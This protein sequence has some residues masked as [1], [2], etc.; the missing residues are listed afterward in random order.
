MAGLCRAMRCA[1]L[2]LTPAD[3]RAG[4]AVLSPPWWLLRVSCTVTTPVP[5]ATAK[6]CIGWFVVGCVVAR[7]VV[8]VAW[9]HLVSLLQPNTPSTPSLVVAAACFMHRDHACAARDCEALH[10]W[11]V[12]GCVVALRVLYVALIVASLL[13]PNTPRA[14]Q[15]MVCGA[16]FMHRDHACAARDCGAL[17]RVVC[18]RLRGMLYVVR[19]AS[20]GC[21]VVAH[22]N[23]QYT[24][25]RTLRSSGCS[26][27]LS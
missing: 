12:V 21:I 10:G 5:P 16:W 2:G 15:L 6:H 22:C 23:R 7:R 20:H 27:A 13:Q 1:S 14:P 24:A 26:R 9:L 19:C 11:F 17:H 8:Y 18:G 25:K 4:C 3:A